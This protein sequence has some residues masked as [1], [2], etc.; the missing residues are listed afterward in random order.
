VTGIIKQSVV[1]LQDV[2]DIH[3]R[4]DEQLIKDTV[5]IRR[6]DIFADG[7]FRPNANVTRDDFART[8][9]LN[10]PLRQALGATPRFTD[11]SGGLAAIAEAITASGSNLRD[12]NFVPQGLMS[13]NG[14]LF[15]PTGTVNRLDVAVAFVR[16]LGLDTE[17]RALANSAVT[18]GGQP[19]VDNGSIPPALR[20]YVQIAINR[21]LLE[22]FPA[23][24]RQIGPGQYVAVPGPRFE[25]NTLVTRSVLAAKLS[26]FAQ[27]FAAGN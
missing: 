13:A 21:G 22:A 4:P 9:S 6:M 3:G 19:L 10:T 5:T 26:L 27:A 15:N 12:W 25:P 14:S 23:E 24:I 18:S 11:V 17:A 2:A 7:T 8:L 1:T 16:S 20:G